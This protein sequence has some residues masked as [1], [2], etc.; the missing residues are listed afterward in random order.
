MLVY[1]FELGFSYVEENLYP[2]R[3]IG[4]FARYYSR[5][6]TDNGFD[7]LRL[8][9]PHDLQ[10]EPEKDGIHC[11]KHGWSFGCASIKDLIRF[12]ANDLGRLHRSGF[13]VFVYEVPDNHVDVGGHQVQYYIGS[14]N[15]VRIMSVRE[16]KQE[17][18]QMK[19]VEDAKNAVHV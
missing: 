14:A 2:V 16:M 8:G 15:L 19:E 13:Q 12:F 17:Y 3:S 7:R 4:P 1:R 11:I 5:Y 10:P 18:R 6:S 9:T